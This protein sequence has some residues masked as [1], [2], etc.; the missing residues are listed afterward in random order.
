MK[1]ELLPTEIMDQI[2]SFVVQLFLPK[3]HES[4]SCLNR[5][6]PKRVLA[7][8]TPAR[9][10]LA[11]LRLAGRVFYRSASALLFQACI[12]DSHCSYSLERLDRLSHSPYAAC[13]RYLRFE[14]NYLAYYGQASRAALN[15]NIRY[16]Q[17]T[18]NNCLSRFQG[19]Q[20]I[21]FDEPNT[22]LSSVDIEQYLD[23]VAGTLR[24][25]EL[26]NLSS[27]HLRPMYTHYLRRILDAIFYSSQDR[28]NN[29]LSRLRH[30]ILHAP[31]FVDDNELAQE[32]P[33]PT[34]AAATPPHAVRVLHLLEL[35]PNL[36]TLTI[37]ARL[38]HIGTAVLPSSLRLRT[39]SLSWIEISSDALLRLLEAVKDTL[40]SISFTEVHLR[41]GTWATVLTRMCFLPSL[42]QLYLKSNGYLWNG[43]TSFLVG[44]SEESELETRSPYDRPA[45]GVLYRHISSNRVAAGLRPL[46]ATPTEHYPSIHKEL[47][48]R[49][50]RYT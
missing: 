26:P 23:T 8:T 17:Y 41:S 24:D 32:L 42:L 30:L 43:T 6:N 33:E 38:L 39:L 25:V 40:R 47:L 2:L 13:V 9:Q 16:I 46:M 34:A 3:P 27:L 10:Q 44:L 37:I 48:T 28:A 5:G 1:L 20:E 4:M 50:R 7:T 15:D 14:S 36:E 18:I 19:L 45:L 29:N 22:G 35:A 11:A 49:V 21:V 12:V 31:H